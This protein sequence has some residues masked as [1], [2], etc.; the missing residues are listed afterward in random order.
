MAQP[1]DANNAPFDRLIRAEI[2]AVSDAVD[3]GYF[4]PVETVL[5]RG[6]ASDSL[7]IV[8]KG[9]V[10]ERD[11]DDVV[12]LRGPGDSFDSRALVQGRGSNAFVAREETLC[13]LL[14]R[15]VAL[16]LID[17]NPR[18]ASFFYLDIAQKLDAASNWREV[19]RFAPLMSARVRDL[20]LHPVVFVDATDTISAAAAWMREV[21]SYAL[22]VPDAH[23]TAIP[24]PTH[25]LHP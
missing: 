16:S 23:R 13:N 17:Q 19:A 24:P 14:P 15:H 21:K 25:P 4:R 9:A 22:F 10:E 1:F 12:A 8:I 11:G 7:F 5:A 3:I 18:F 6:G 20:F 2:R